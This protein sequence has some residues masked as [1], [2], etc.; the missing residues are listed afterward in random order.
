MYCTNNLG[1]A[2]YILSSRR[3]KFHQIIPHGKAPADILFLDPDNEARSIEVDYAT[4]NDLASASSYHKT[5]RDL[6]R[7]IQSAISEQTEPKN[8]EVIRG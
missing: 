2:A 1:L 4:G 6:R 3:L 8:S 7:L 5:L